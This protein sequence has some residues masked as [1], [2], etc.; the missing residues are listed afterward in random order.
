MSTP[1]ASSSGPSLQKLTLSKQP[2]GCNGSHA[3]QKEKLHR[4]F[5]SGSGFLEIEEIEEQKS[6]RVRGRREEEGG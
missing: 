3:L 4:L 1:L 2:D 6:Q 5:G